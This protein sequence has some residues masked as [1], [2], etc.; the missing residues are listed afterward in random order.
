MPKYQM[1]SGPYGPN[2]YYLCSYLSM[3]AVK[4]LFLALSKPISLPQITFFYGKNLSL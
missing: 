2:F 4:K 1:S 3:H